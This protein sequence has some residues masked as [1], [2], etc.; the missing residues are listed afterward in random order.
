VVRDKETKEYAPEERTAI[1]TRAWKKG[2]ICF[3]CGVSTIRFSPP[4]IAQEEHIDTALE[5]FDQAVTEI[6]KEM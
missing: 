3:G 4:L 5:I 2:L 6:E 1:V